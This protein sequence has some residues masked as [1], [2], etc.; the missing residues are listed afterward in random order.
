MGKRRDKG[1]GPGKSTSFKG[2]KVSTVAGLRE[3]T[4]ELHLTSHNYTF[5]GL[6]KEDE[7]YLGSNEEVLKAFTFGLTWMNLHFRNIL[8]SPLF[9]FLNIHMVYIMKDVKVDWTFSGVCTMEKASPKAQLVE[10]PPADVEDT[11]DVSLIFGWGRSSGEG[12]G[13][14]LQ[15]LVWKIPWTDGAWWAI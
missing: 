12:N 3:C 2:L 15:S 9:F 8:F 7:P 11:R 10:N 1:P 14:P 4:G 6:L 13:N 5:W